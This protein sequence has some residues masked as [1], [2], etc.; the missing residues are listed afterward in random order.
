MILLSESRICHSFS[1]LL[2][3]AAKL[4]DAHCKVEVASEARKFSCVPWVIGT[5]AES[6]WNF[7]GL[8]FKPSDMLTMVIVSIEE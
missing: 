7:C 4:G 5:I 3:A 8:F 1:V 2:T 6:K